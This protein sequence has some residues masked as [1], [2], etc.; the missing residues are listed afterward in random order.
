MGR[1]SAGLAGIAAAAIALVTGIAIESGL[2]QGPAAGMRILADD[3]GPTAIDATDDDM[4]PTAVPASVNDDM[5]PTAIRASVNDDM[6]PT[7]I[8]KLG[9]ATDKVNDDMGPTSL[10][11]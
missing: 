9:S 10:A 8:G 1:K 11:A 2:P 4:G 7:M 6:G 3:M 5:G